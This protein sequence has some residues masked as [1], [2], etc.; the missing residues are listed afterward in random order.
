[1]PTGMNGISLA[2]NNQMCEIRFDTTQYSSNK[3]L[4]RKA[5]RKIHKKGIN[6]KL[7]TK[8]FADGL[9]ILIIGTVVG[10]TYAIRDFLL[11]IIDPIA[12]SKL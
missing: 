1:M 9:L 10:T 12:Q 3:R 7:D 5:K 2:G 4:I 11:Y 6:A 8:A